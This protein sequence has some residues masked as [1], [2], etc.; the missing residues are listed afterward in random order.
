MRISPSSWTMS[1]SLTN[2]SSR[3]RQTPATGSVS[4]STRQVPS[5]K[6]ALA[7]FSSPAF[8][9][10][11]RAHGRPRQ[12]RDRRDR[13]DHQ[14]TPA[15]CLAPGTRRHLCRKPELD[16][17]LSGGDLRPAVRVLLLLLL[18]GALTSGQ[19]LL[20]VEPSSGCRSP[21]LGWPASDYV[22]PRYRRDRSG[23][24]VPLSAAR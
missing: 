22:V 14:R 2:M 7:A 15:P 20:H 8:A 13:G 23:S 6:V 12:E 5:P 17:L 10:R 1:K 4:A 24:A 9:R 18:H 19:N 11:R 21:G 16:P 3:T